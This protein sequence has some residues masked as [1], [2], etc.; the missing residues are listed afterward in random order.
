MPYR[1]ATAQYI[2]L[3]K[4][5]HKADNLCGCGDPSEIRTPDTLIKSSVAPELL[6]TSSAQTFAE[7]PYYLNISSL[8]TVSTAFFKVLNAVNPP[9]LMR[10]VLNTSNLFT[11]LFRLLVAM[12][13]LRRCVY[14][15][16]FFINISYMF[17]FYFICY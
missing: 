9:M 17:F 6:P 16:I 5:P 15:T 11:F 1:L 13:L 10:G 8:T 12:Y 14:L 7:A 3:I 2:K 4:Q